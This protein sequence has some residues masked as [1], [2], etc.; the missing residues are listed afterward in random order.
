MEAFVRI[1][2]RC[3]TTECKAAFKYFNKK[4][5]L[6]A[7]RQELMFER[8]LWPSAHVDLK[9]VRSRILL[10]YDRIRRVFHSDE[11]W[12]KFVL[13]R[14]LLC[15]FD[16]ATCIL[17]DGYRRSFCL[18]ISDRKPSQNAFNFSFP[19]MCYIA[20]PSN[21]SSHLVSSLL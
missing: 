11:N 18:H 14:R 2:F 5:R 17:A 20:C 10:R 3:K 7:A 9:F 13:T 16:V 15:L 4:D 19:H 12:S 6:I 8:H 1:F 21:S